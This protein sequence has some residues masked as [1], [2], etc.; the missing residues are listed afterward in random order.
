MSDATKQNPA[1]ETKVSAIPEG[2]IPMSAPV[3]RLQVP[4]KEGFVRYWF[5]GDYNRLARAQQ[6]GYRFVD[7]SEVRVNNLDVAGNP[8]NS[9]NTDMGSRVSIVTGDEVGTDGQP[10]RLYLMEI[11]KELYEHGQKLLQERNDSVAEA[12]R[13]GV[14]GA[15]DE[16]YRDK[17]ARYSKSG[18]PDLFNPHKRRR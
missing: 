2:Y 12:L 11:P 15:D 8:A 17:A 6:A 3:Q 9:G 1:N 4:E 13:A 18:V 14:I 7:Q 5:R 10:N 16:D